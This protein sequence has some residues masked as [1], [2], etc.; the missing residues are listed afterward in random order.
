MWAGREPV[1]GYARPG[2]AALALVL[3]L[4]AAGCST[5]YQNAVPLSW[6]SG[7][8]YTEEAGPGGLIKVTYNGNKWM[9][10]YQVQ[11]Y[12]LY[13]CAEIAQRQGSPYFALYQTLPDALQNRTSKEVKPTTLLGIPHAEVYIGL[14]KT[15]TPGLLSTAEVLASLKPAIV[16]GAK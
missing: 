12:A 2:K 11:D 6:A 1:N 9:Q 3:G 16:A 4:M 14:Y 15:A 8:G 10:M 5:T 7:A 13:R